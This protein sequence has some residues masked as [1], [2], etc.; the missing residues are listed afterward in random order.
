MWLASPP[1]VHSALLCAGPGPVSLVA[2]AAGWSSMSVEY[3]AVAHEL[4]VV[5]AGMQ[6]GR[7]RGPALSFVW[8][9]MCRMWRG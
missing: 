6:A 8:V 4:C 3:A 7:G 2:A 5:V 1:E 9:L